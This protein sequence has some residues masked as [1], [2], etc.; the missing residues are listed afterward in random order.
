[1]KKL[2]TVF[3]LI[4]SVSMAQEC[5]ETITSSQETQSHVE[6]TT[7]VPEHLKGATLTITKAD[8]TSETVK[9]EDYMLVKRKHKR[10]VVGITTQTKTLLCEKK[11][12]KNAENILSLEAVSGQA[13]LEKNIISKS[14]VEVKT[15]KGLGLGLMYQR[16]IYKDLYLGGKVDS[17][18]NVGLNIGVGF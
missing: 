15:K 5:G 12:E 10:P 17:N 2:I 9:A 7:A 8:G 1:M 3:M 16:N 14:E 11:S 4:S 13:G 18:E 6:V